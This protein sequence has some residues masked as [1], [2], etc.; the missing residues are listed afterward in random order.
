M[1]QAAEY[2][3]QK[4]VNEAILTQALN[5]CPVCSFLILYVFGNVKFYC[6]FCVLKVTEKDTELFVQKKYIVHHHIK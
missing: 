3:K 5:H 1:V 4:L 6:I 2:I